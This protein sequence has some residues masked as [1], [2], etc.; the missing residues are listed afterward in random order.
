[1]WLLVEKPTFLWIILPFSSSPITYLLPTLPFNW[2]SRIC[3]WKPKSE[4][5]G[6]ELVREGRAQQY[7]LPLV[8]LDSF[9][10]MVEEE[11]EA[12]WGAGKVG[13]EGERRKCGFRC[14]PR[15]RHGASAREEFGLW[16]L[17]ALQRGLK[18]ASCSAHPACLC[19]LVKGNLGW[20]CRAH[21]WQP[22]QSIAYWTRPII[23]Q[24]AMH[25]MKGIREKS[26]NCFNSAFCSHML[27]LPSLLLM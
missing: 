6:G 20:L 23:M 3:L 18:A 16:L 24:P 27:G 11:A 12:R 22:L 17:K 26:L 9:G 4:A 13:A 5:P 14:S 25:S 2:L 7:W 15:P 8:P 19:L 1:M 10:R 21:K